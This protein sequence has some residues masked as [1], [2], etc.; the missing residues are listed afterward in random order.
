LQFTT[1]EV[2]I[3]SRSVSYLSTLVKLQTSVP[4]LSGIRARASGWNV[5][6]LK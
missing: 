5:V 3:V 4:S 2:G 1:E 6:L